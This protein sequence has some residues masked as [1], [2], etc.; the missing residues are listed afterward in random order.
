VDTILSNYL[1]SDIFG[2]FNRLFTKSI[3]QDK[4]FLGAF[5]LGLMPRKFDCDDPVDKIIYEEDQDVAEMYFIMEGK[6]GFAINSF[7]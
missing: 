3:S 5:A 1:F 7:S 2:G 6:I 4:R